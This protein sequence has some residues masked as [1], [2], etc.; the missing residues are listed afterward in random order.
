MKHLNSLSAGIKTTAQDEAN[1]AK[2][3]QRGNEITEQT[4][5]AQD[6]LN[7]SLAEARK[8]YREGAISAGTYAKHVSELKKNSIGVGMLG[9]M[10][11]DTIT[12]GAGTDTILGDNGFVQMDAQGNKYAQVRTLSA[13][14]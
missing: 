2:I 8:L 11:A 4:R 9:G 10:G 13:K 7:R 3:M 6:R 5:S 12:A 1:R 14:I